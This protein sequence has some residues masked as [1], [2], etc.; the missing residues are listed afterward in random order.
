VAGVIWLAGYL[1]DVLIPFA[2]ALLLAYLTNPLVS[3]IQ[4]KISNRVAAVFISLLLIIVL[5]VLLC[6]FIIP[7]I[8]GDHACRPVRRQ[9]LDGFRP[10]RPRLCGGADYPGC[11]PGS[12]N[13][14]QAYPN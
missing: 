14:G 7:M 12:Q 4:K 13:Y 5:A 1:S 11:H 2:V 6:W 10:Y 8:A 9:Y 3:L